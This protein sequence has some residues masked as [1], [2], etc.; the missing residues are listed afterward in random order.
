MC[1]AL[2]CSFKCCWI[3]NRPTILVDRICSGGSKSHGRG[4]FLILIKKIQ[5]LP[6][7]FDRSHRTEGEEIRGR[8]KLSEN[9]LWEWHLRDVRSRPDQERRTVNDSGSSGKPRFS[10]LIL[11]VLRLSWRSFAALADV[12]KKSVRN[13]KKRPCKS[14]ENTWAQMIVNCQCDPVRPVCRTRYHCNHSFIR[15]LRVIP[16]NSSHSSSLLAP[17]VLVVPTKTCVLCPFSGL[18]NNLRFRELR[19]SFARCWGRC[20]ALSGWESAVRNG[21]AKVTYGMKRSVDKSD[22]SSK[23]E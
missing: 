18:H 8:V 2:R 16:R 13:F 19:R 15:I 5:T 14:I 4:R 23:S 10:C 6:W 20:G 1:I 3:I 17:R 21:A 11:Q 7:K 12:H 22:A 9:V